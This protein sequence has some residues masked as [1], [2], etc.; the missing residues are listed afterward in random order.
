MRRNRA[1]LQV[2]EMEPRVV[3]STASNL[4]PR[5]A[6]TSLYST[7]VDNQGRP[8]AQGLTDSHWRI[9]SA[10]SPD[11]PG[12]AYTVIDNGFPFNGYWL[13]GDSNSE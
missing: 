9:I 3:P 11:T 12:H 13:P 2:E 8:L 10:P 4:L 5:E 7:G 6:I 1:R